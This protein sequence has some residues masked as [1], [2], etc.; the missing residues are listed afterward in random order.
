MDDWFKGL[1]TILHQAQMEFKKTCNEVN[2]YNFI[3]L[4]CHDC[5]EVEYTIM[6]HLQIVNFE[7]NLYLIVHLYVYTCVYIIYEPYMPTVLSLVCAIK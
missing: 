2:P 5:V 4:H 3:K 1:G 7:F 6:L